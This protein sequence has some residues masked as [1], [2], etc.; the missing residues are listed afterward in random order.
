MLQNFSKSSRTDY[1]S[2]PCNSI[3]NDTLQTPFKIIELFSKNL[4][5]FLF[6]IEHLIRFGKDASSAIDSKDYSKIVSDCLIIQSKLNL[7]SV[8]VKKLFSVA[9]PFQKRDKLYCSYDSTLPV[10]NEITVSLNEIVIT[11]KSLRGSQ[12]ICEIVSSIVNEI[13]VLVEWYNNQCNLINSKSSTLSESQTLDVINQIETV[14]VQFQL[15]IQSFYKSAFVESYHSSVTPKTGDEVFADDVDFDLQEAEKI[16]SEENFLKIEHV[17]I[18]SIL[19]SSRISACS[20]AL[21]NLFSTLSDIQLTSIDVDCSCLISLMSQLYLL[22]SRVVSESLRFHKACNKLEY[23]L[24]RLFNSLFARGF[25]RKNED[26]ETTDEK[27]EDNVAGTGMGEGEGNK[28][29]SDQRDE[30]QLLGLD[31]AQNQPSGE[32]SDKDNNDPDKGKEMENDFNGDLFDV[33][34]KEVPEDQEE[35]AEEKP[36]FDREM[37]EDLNDEEVV[38]EKLWDEEDDGPKENEKEKEE[39]L[40]KDSKVHGGQENNEMVADMD[41]NDKKEK[42][43]QDPTRKLED[44]E[45]KK[46][47]DD[48]SKEDGDE[49]DEAMGENPGLGNLILY[50]FC[51]FLVNDNFEDNSEENNK[52]E[53]DLPE[54]LKM[55]EDGNDNDGEEDA[56][57]P[58]DDEACNEINDA[59]PSS[60]GEDVDDSE[61]AIEENKSLEPEPSDEGDLKEDEKNDKESADETDEQNI[62]RMPMEGTDDPNETSADNIILPEGD[63]TE[64]KEDQ[65]ALSNF[66]LII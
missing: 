11:L 31:E 55:E 45:T 27:F 18:T 15:E 39:K 17:R 8:R 16:S 48:K 46:E 25:C 7:L 65:D 52:I 19:K 20:D 50:I 3:L 29:V 34:K 21:S 59:D 4:N 2:N 26:P 9:L 37:G 22:Y 13:S 57:D 53:L 58:A 5:S 12:V 66:I 61:P 47:I 42:D 35:D 54:E 36:E 28:D 1:I 30:E 10:L 51:N 62:E 38:D 33:E 14:V 32:K 41:K 40:E 60:D 56:Q 63:T 43:K 44:E 23:V 6:K 49:E 64:A 24:L